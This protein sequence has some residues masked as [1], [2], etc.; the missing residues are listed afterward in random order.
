MH[1]IFI[2]ISLFILSSCSNVSDSNNTEDDVETEKINY[3]TNG[4]GNLN[5]AINTLLAKHSKIY[6]RTYGSNKSGI[7]DTFTYSVSYGSSGSSGSYSYSY[8]YIF[9]DDGRYRLSYS[10]S[11][12]TGSGSNGYS[13]PSESGTFSLFSENGFY[14]VKMKNSKGTEKIYRYMVSERYLVFLD[15][16][17]TTKY[18]LDLDE[19]AYTF[20]AEDDDL[21]KLNCYKRNTG[22]DGILGKWTYHIGES[23]TSSGKDRFGNYYSNTYWPTTYSVEFSIDGLFS[24]T[25]TIISNENGFSRS[26]NTVKGVFGV[27][28]TEENDFQL[29]MVSYSETKLLTHIKVSKNYL[30]TEKDLNNIIA[31]FEVSYESVIG[32]APETITLEENAF[33]TSEH[34]PT[35]ACD[36]YIFNGWYIGDERVSADKISVTGNVVLTANWIKLLSVTYESK[37]GKIPSSFLVQPNSTLSA[38]QL[39]SLYDGDYTFLG[40]YYNENKAV[41]GE[42]R[43]TTDVILQAKW[44]KDADY[45]N[46]ITDEQEKYKFMIK[47]LSGTWLLHG[48]DT[49]YQV[50]ISQS[51]HRVLNSNY[52]YE[53]DY[54]HVCPSINNSTLNYYFSENSTYLDGYMYYIDNK[55][56][57]TD[58]HTWESVSSYMIWKYSVKDGKLWLK[59]TNSY[60]TR[61]NLSSKN[62]YTQNDIESYILTGKDTKKNCNIV[63]YPYP[64][65][66]SYGNESENLYFMK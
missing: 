36:G 16:T 50:K 6:E 4:I 17:D 49:N 9:S 53:Y 10:Q 15:S 23:W 57:Y 41:A 29:A 42:F 3:D 43:V 63:Y 1:F 5:N 12:G 7:I 48:T 46:S 13:L 22:S 11:T 14:Y 24:F 64:Y 65:G 18:E 28:E 55:S 44:L 37:Y 56:V 62:Q 27:I 26:E 35:L 32:L 52:L 51:Y 31:F 40:W 58:S 60:E 20:N 59:K 2:V 21:K 25:R 19:A 54:N 47:E 34:L 39:P 61:G 66:T 45:W 33:L 38:T 8:T 30:Y